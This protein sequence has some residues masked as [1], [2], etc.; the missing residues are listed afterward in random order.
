MSLGKAKAIPLALMVIFCFCGLASG[1][2][3]K[4]DATDRYFE[5]KRDVNIQGSQVSGFFANFPVLFDSKTDPTDL[6][7]DLR[8]EANGGHVRSDYGYDIVFATADGQEI[9]KHEIEKYVPTSGE[10]VAW[11]NVTLTGSNQTIYIYYGISVTP[12]DTQHIEDVWDSNFV[13]VQHLSEISPNDHLDSTSN[14]N[15]STTI[16]VATQGSAA[17]QIDGADAFNGAQALEPQHHVIIPDNVNGS[18]DF[19][20]QI[21]IEAWIKDNVED[22][23]RIVYKHW[24]M[25]MM[26]TSDYEGRLHAWVKVGSVC[27]HVK[28]KKGLIGT[29]SNYY[30]VFTWDGRLGQDNLL[31]LYLDGSE[32]SYVGGTQ[33]NVQ[34]TIDNSDDPL[35]IGSDDVDES[36]NGIIDEV[37]LSN[38]AR[39]VSWIE[40][41]YN[42]MVSPAAFYTVGDA[43]TTL[44]ELSYFRATSHDS[45]VLLEWATETELDNAGFN[46]W[47]SEEKDGQYVRINPYLIPNEGEAGFGA[48]YNFTDYDVQNGKIYF[49][50]LEDIDISGRITFHGPVPAI[51]HDIIIFWPP[52]KI[53]LPSGAFLFSW[54]SSNNYSFKVEIS[55]NPSFPASETFSYPE[56][57]LISGNSLCLTQR[58]WEMILEKAQQSQGQL[59]WRV[60]AKGPDGREVFSDWKIFFIENNRPP[61]E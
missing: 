59:F 7:L 4:I 40:T 46:L 8:T 2:T 15:D 39:S 60:R 29:V 32:M 28:S 31:H 6:Q 56:H 54:S 12:F 43:Y 22:Q 51:P 3:V 42:S 52:D 61:E 50:K 47:R 38:K 17:G 10:Y 1:Y 45:A 34:G 53:V 58:E 23:R 20:D 5:Y 25:Y 44:V 19:T 33:E 9:L 24:E 41:A 36:W 49:Y 26:R 18:L 35:Y 11:V 13:M 55:P 16:T 30:C 37:R 57:G 48:E 27:R 14:N 21:T